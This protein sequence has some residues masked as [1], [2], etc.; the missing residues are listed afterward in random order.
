MLQVVFQCKKYSKKPLGKVTHRK[1]VI[2]TA[3]IFAVYLVIISMTSVVDYLCWVYEIRFILAL[4]KPG[5][6]EIYVFFS[7]WGMQT[8]CVMYHARSLAHKPTSQHSSI[9]KDTE[10]K[11]NLITSNFVYQNWYSTTEVMLFSIIIFKGLSINYRSGLEKISS[12][13]PAI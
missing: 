4:K 12:S 1:T 8:G 11:F 5:L 6:R 2:F 7:N 3:D 13:G 10:K 9:L